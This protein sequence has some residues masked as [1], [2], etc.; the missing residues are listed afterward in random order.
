[1][2]TVSPP[3][4]INDTLTTGH[5]TTSAYLAN[6]DKDVQV[7]VRGAFVGNVR[8]RA[9]YDQGVTYDDV[10]VFTAP[11]MIKVRPPGTPLLLL[12][13]S[14]GGDYTSGSAGV[15]LGY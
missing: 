1:M 5:L 15:F 6:L 13:A 7:T 12:D 2:T 8:L 9:S 11:D 14:G 4:V 10:Y 3:A